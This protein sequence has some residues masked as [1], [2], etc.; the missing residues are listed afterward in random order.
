M[1]KTARPDLENDPEL[2]A[3]VFNSIQDG[4]SILDKE[5]NIAR[6]NPTMEKWY[7]HKMPLAGKKCYDAYHGTHDI[8]NPCPS[9]RALETKA[10]AVDIVPYHGPGGKVLGWLELFSFPLVDKENN[11]IGVLEFVKDVTEKHKYEDLL[12]QENERLKELDEIRQAFI[13]KA[14]HELKTPVTNITGAIQLFEKM[15]DPRTAG[16]MKNILDILSRGSNRLQRLVM[17]L[18]DFSRAELKKIEL[19]KQEIDL[20]PMISDIIAE[21]E[22]K[23]KEKNHQINLKLPNTC[24]IRADPLRIEEVIINLVMNA[25]KYT[26][27]NGNIIISLDATQTHVK[28]AVIDDGIGLTDDEKKILFTKFGSV[29]R[30]QMEGKIETYGTGVGLFIS[31]EIIEAH[32]GR[33]WAE[34]NGRDKGSTF[35]FMIPKNA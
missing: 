28:L 13:I 3:L 6:V 19:D 26:P 8:C 15:I 18:L 7:R 17:K 30:K 24:I 12:K 33:I 32:G 10:A 5:L 20:I 35:S 4:I 21:L 25:I 29:Y 31:K 14:T 11:I 23:I 22:Y 2:Y 27:R 34:S 9:V 16:S 1:A